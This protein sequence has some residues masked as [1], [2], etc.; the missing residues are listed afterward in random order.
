MDVRLKAVNWGGGRKGK[1]PSI[2]LQVKS[3]AALTG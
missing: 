3:M 2:N 1:G